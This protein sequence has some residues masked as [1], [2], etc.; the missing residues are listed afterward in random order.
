MNK[1]IKYTMIL[2]M[3]FIM[4]SITLAPVFAS[5]KQSF[6]F[7]TISYRDLANSV[8]NSLKTT[9]YMQEMQAK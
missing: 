6:T 3:T 4:L 1:I 2:A 8:P 9:Y 5:E 7:T